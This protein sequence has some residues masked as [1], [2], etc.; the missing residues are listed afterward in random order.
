VQPG[1]NPMLTYND[2]FIE[3]SNSMVQPFYQPQFVD[4]ILPSYTPLYQQEES[5]E[6]GDRSY[7]ESYGDEIN[8]DF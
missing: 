7:Y 2:C 6:N 8:D 1:E 5:S 4:W 3:L